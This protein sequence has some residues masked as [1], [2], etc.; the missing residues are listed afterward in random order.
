MKKLMQSLIVMGIVLILF[1]E[2]TAAMNGN[3][4]ESTKQEFGVTIKNKIQLKSGNKQSLPFNVLQGYHNPLLIHKEDNGS[5]NINDIVLKTR[6]YTA[7]IIKT[8][9]KYSLEI[10]AE[11]EIK[12]IETDT[13]YINAMKERKATEERTKNNRVMTNKPKN[14]TFGVPLVITISPK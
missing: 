6:L 14:T 12:K 2:T 13:L 8:G 9:E 1:T 7:K 4:D 3:N 10:T 11:K 5:I